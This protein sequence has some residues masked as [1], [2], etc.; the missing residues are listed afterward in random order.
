MA[1]DAKPPF[2]WL[3]RLTRELYQE[4]TLPAIPEQVSLVVQAAVD[5]DAAVCHCRNASTAQQLTDSLR[6]QA[7]TGD[8]NFIEAESDLP[9]T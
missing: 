9:N 3:D 1:S 6:I 7:Q 8:V 2:D 5:G 4:W